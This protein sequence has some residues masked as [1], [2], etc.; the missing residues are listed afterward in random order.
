MGKKIFI[1]TP[2]PRARVERLEERETIARE[3]ISGSIGVRPKEKSRQKRDVKAQARMNRDTTKRQRRM[4]K[5]RKSS[6]NY[7]PGDLVYHRRRPTVPMLVMTI[8]TDY[9]D[10]VVEVMIG[11]DMIRYKAINL[12]KFECED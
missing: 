3:F 11:A 9:R 5:H 8:C 4:K 6:I 1:D 12:R 2:E 7:E 10:I